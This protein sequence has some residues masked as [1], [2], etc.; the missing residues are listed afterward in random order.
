MQKGKRLATSTRLV[1][2]KKFQPHGCIDIWM[3]GDLLYYEATGPF[4][5]ELV[6]ALAVAQADILKN[7]T[8]TRPWASISCV[9]QCVLMSPDAMTRYAEIMR[10]PKPEGKTPVATA[11]VIGPEVEGRDIVAPHFVKI[12]AD[13]ERPMQIFETLEDAK[14]WAQDMIAGALSRDMK[15]TAAAPVK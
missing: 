6:D 11:F 12:Y 8:A 2:I 13:I 14:R 4:N 7:I 1:P 10:I 15:N 3:E 9:K 5:T